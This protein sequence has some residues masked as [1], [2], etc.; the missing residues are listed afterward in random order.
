MTMLVRESDLPDIIRKPIKNSEARKVLAHISDWHEQAHD[1]W[2]LRANAQQKK[3]DDGD[4]F[5][6]AEVYKTLI[7][8]MESDQ[9]SMA[10]RRQLT[11]SEQCLSEELAAT[12]GQPIKKV[13]L[14][15]EEVLHRIS[16]QYELNNTNPF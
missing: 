16:D 14:W 5:G 4:P 13:C 3:L 8:R 15:Y 10:D 7:L 11:Q 1:Q 6:V 9:L 2:K 12:L